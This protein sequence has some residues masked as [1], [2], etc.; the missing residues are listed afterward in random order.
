MQQQYLQTIKKVDWPLLWSETSQSSAL[1]SDS[2]LKFSLKFSA[3]VLNCHLRYN[4]FIY[5]PDALQ[6]SAFF[7][8]YCFILQLE[9]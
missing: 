6:M 4:E 2:V 5:I 9:A 8:V 3:I 7:W 1:Y